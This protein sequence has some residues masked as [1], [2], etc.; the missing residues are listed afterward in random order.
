LPDRY[1]YFFRPF[2]PEDSNTL[3]I[4]W[5]EYPC[6]HGDRNV[7]QTQGCLKLTASIRLGLYFGL[8]HNSADVV[9]YGYQAASTLLISANGG[10]L[11][12]I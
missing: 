2:E 12:R 4:L 6:K 5:L 10:H 7:W 9:R 1:R 8:F 11:S 3:L